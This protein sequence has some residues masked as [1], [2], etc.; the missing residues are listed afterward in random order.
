MS[1]G[2]GDESHAETRRNSFAEERK[3]LFYSD[4]LVKVVF[5]VL[6]TIQM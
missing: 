2:D 1:E 5:L 3:T 6:D 4:L